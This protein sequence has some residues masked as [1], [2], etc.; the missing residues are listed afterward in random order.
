MTKSIIYVLGNPIEPSD[1][2]AV[3]LIPLLKRKLPHINFIHFDPTEELPPNNK[4]LTVIDTV[5]GIKKVKKYTNLNLWS[6]SPRVTAHDYDLPLTLGIL[7]K[8]GKIKEVTIIGI[9]SKGN[10][11]RI[12][13]DIKNILNA[14]GT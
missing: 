2:Q 11:E 14:S 13:N 1:R 8:L 5:M 4:K 9:P 7:K 12:T 10:F 3:K 6:L